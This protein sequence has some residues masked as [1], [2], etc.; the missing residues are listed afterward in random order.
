M[1]RATIQADHSEALSLRSFCLSAALTISVGSV[2][3]SCGS[4][5]FRADSSGIE[6]IPNLVVELAG[7]VI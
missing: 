4:H 2:H 1:S 3:I 6:Q 5:A 7:L